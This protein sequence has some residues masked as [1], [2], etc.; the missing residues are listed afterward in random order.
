MSVMTEYTIHELAKIS[1]VSSR[2]LRHYDAIGLL[3]PLK[4]NA[5]GYRIYGPNEVNLLQQILVHKTNGLKLETI[6]Q[7]LDDPSFDMVKALRH[8]KE[9]LLAQKDELDNIISTIDKSIQNYQ[10]KT[11]MSDNQKFMN[12][13]KKLIADND[14]K[15]GAEVKKRWGEDTWKKSNQSFQNMSKEQLDGAALIEK[16][17]KDTL[18]EAF[19]AKDPA[20]EM[21]QKAV[22]LHKMWL[23]I[24]WPNYS[25]AA[26]QGLAQMYVDDVRFHHYFNDQKELAEFFRDA[27]EVANT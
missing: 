8:Q 12:L 21:A 6:R 15:Y 24:F 20:G 2:T 14:Q 10:G 3:R 25:Y 27:V 22:E 23:S 19:A 18:A 4:K 9:L 1:G 13:K 7:I 17:F 16:E 11:I 26:H 5:A